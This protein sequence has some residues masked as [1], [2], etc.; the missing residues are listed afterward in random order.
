MARQVKPL[1]VKEIRD[2]KPKD[3]AYR[4]YDGEGLQLVVYPSGK[5]VWRF[6]YIDID[7]KRKSYTIGD[8]DLIHRDDARKQREEFRRRLEMGESIIEPVSETF[9]KVFEDWYVRWEK[10][11]TPKHAKKVKSGVSRDCHPVLGRMEINSIKPRD[12]VNALSPIEKRGAL[13][14]LKT[15][16]TGLNLCFDFAVARGLCEYNPSR[17]VSNNA[18]HSKPVVSHRS[19]PPEEI[20]TMHE[21]FEN[22]RFNLPVRRCTEFVMRTMVRVGEATYAEWSEIDWDKKLWIIPAEKMKMRRDH[23][24]PLSTQCM[25]ILEEMQE[26]SSHLEYIFPNYNLTTYINR[27]NPLMSLKRAKINTTMHGLRHLASTILNEKG[28]FRPDVIESAL[29]HQDQNSIRATYNKAEYIKERGE[30]MQW[31]SDL[32]D[33]CK[34]EKTNRE[35]ISFLILK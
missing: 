18:F 21:Y 19:L 27:D 25:S 15:I 26:I 12:I 29:A 31:W 34:D 3:K 30:M 2:A 4:L 10:S 28:L 35:A 23:I 6:D 7:K 5:K 32:I 13:E 17:M 9:Y 1:S 8:A 20:Y 24:V 11:V 22:P 14:Q 33:Q 16:K